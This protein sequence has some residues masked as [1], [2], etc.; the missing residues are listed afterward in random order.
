MFF[1]YKCPKRERM[2]PYL[3]PSLKFW[4]H[5]IAHGEHTKRFWR[6]KWTHVREKCDLAKCAWNYSVDLVV[7]RRPYI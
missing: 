6:E 4:T 7:T 3:H 1:R 5:L 2:G